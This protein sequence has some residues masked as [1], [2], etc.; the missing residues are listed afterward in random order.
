MSDLSGIDFGKLLSGALGQYTKGGDD[1]STGIGQFQDQ[2]KNTQAHQANL[3]ALAFAAGL[4]KPTQTGSFGESVGNAGQG[5]I[6]ALQQQRQI[7]FERQAKILELQSAKQQLLGQQLSTL[8]PYWKIQQASNAFGTLLGGGAPGGAGGLPGAGGAS[9]GGPGASPGGGGAISP[10]DPRAKYGAAMRY[11]IASGDKNAADL[12]TTMMN[13]DPDVQ[14]AVKGGVAGAEA[15]AKAP[16]DMKEITLPNGQKRMV[17]VSQIVGAVGG[18]G[19]GFHTGHAASGGT[20]AASGTLANLPIPP[21]GGAAPSVSRETPSAEPSPQSTDAS[22]AL[23]IPSGPSTVDTTLQSM[24]AK[25]AEGIPDSLKGLADQE[26][27]LQGLMHVYEKYEPG[28]FA[29]Q[30]ADIVGALRGVGIDMPATDTA[31]PEKFEQAMK[32]AM[33]GVFKKV[34]EIGGQ[35]KVAELDGLTKTMAVPVLQ[36]GAVQSIG[37]QSLGVLHWKQDMDR[38]YA[39][40]YAGG[41]VTDPGTWQAEWLDK[42][43]L[44]GYVAQSLAKLPVKGVAL[45]AVPDGGLGIADKD[46]TDSAGKIIA[47]KGDKVI[48][49]GDDFVP[50]DRVG[51]HLA[52]IGA[53]G[54]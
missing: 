49:Y 5:A 13:N 53:S 34:Q 38:D 25:Q 47:K 11:A 26:Q 29:E 10:S 4:L 19:G 12:I 33:Q 16:Y 3:P 24:A 6:G 36:P 48:R 9:V 1:L 22:P 30:K 20:G 46:Y 44:G 45:N 23:G 54:G 37:A 15:S 21:T 39:K 18:G 32:Y 28:K 27:N 17:P 52:K 41:K 35:V 50:I 8:Q 51:E 2:I 14:A 43:P 31:N 42:H 7:D 40:A